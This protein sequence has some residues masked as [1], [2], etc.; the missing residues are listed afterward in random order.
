MHAVDSFHGPS[1]VCAGHNSI[2]QCAVDALSGEGR[3]LLEHL[4]VAGRRG[5]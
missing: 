1:V 3:N 4:S 5:G 2:V